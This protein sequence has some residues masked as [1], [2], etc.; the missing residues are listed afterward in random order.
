MPKDKVKTNEIQYIYD[1]NNGYT[2]TEVVKYLK[3]D[4]F[5]SFKD[6]EELY[7]HLRDN[8]I[9][10]KIDGVDKSISMQELF[11]VK[12]YKGKET[13]VKFKNSFID[14]IKKSIPKSNT[15]EQGEF[16]FSSAEE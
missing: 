9:L 8:N 4:G 5:D 15:A 1:E 7:K 12:K 16:S 6:A 3:E 10:T 13:G 14:W 2:A 11:L